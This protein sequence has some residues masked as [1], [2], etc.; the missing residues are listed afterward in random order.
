MLI[1]LLFTISVTKNNLCLKNSKFIVE[2]EKT[3]VRSIDFLSLCFKIKNYSLLIY[4]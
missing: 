1:N 2:L 4:S 3:Y